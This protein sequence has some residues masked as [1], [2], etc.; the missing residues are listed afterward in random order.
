M[1]GCA[2]GGGN[3]PQVGQRIQE[4]I[5]YDCAY[6]ILR[7]DAMKIQVDLR[8]D[9]TNKN[10]LYGYLKSAKNQPQYICTTF[11]PMLQQIDIILGN[12]PN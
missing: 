12:P 5:S 6:N 10:I 1:C 11:L 8:N 9:L 3:I 4:P 2:G 7:V